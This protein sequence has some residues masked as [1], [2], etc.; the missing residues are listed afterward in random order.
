MQIVR[1]GASHSLEFLSDFRI[2][3]DNNDIY[4]TRNTA[5]DMDRDFKVGALLKTSGAQSYA[6]PDDGNAYRFVLLWCRPFRVP[7]GI[8]ELK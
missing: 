1:R 7:I 3:L 2:D 5:L 4:L 6:L 8:G